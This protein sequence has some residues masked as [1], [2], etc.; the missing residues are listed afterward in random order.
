MTEQKDILKIPNTALRFRPPVPRAR[1]TPVVWILGRDGGPVAV[2]VTL[3]IPTGPRRRSYV[4]TS[5]WSRRS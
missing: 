2:R 5:R 4:A 1:R 3:G